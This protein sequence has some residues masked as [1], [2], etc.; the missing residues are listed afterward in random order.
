MS[1]NKKPPKWFA[2][3]DYSYLSGLDMQGWL[4][5]LSQCHHWASETEKM[6]AGEPTFE[7]EWKHVPQ[8]QGCFPAY[9]GPPTIAVIYDSSLASRGERATESHLINTPAIP[10]KYFTGPK[11]EIRVNL[12][13]PDGEIMEQL[14]V[15]LK[16]VRKRLPSSGTRPG[17]KALNS[18]IRSQTT[19]GWINH[20][21]VEITELRYHERKVGRTVTNADLGNWLFPK[22]NNPDKTV[23]DALKTLNRAL[24]A[25]PALWAQ[26]YGRA[27]LPG[28]PT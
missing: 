3:K 10:L 14:E 23:C 11:L 15:L 6:A 25:I 1:S 7:E 27:R 2:E 16:D 28:I 4:K 5:Q 13:A 19:N 20:K 21:I 24:A 8:V 9:V 18:S 17:K 12:D 22:R 26:V